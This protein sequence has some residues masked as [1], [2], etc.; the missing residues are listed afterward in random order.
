MAYLGILGVFVA[1]VGSTGLALV[2]LPA[3]TG[4]RPVPPAALRPWASLLLIG[5]VASM[6]ALEI[7]L[8]TDDFSIAYVANNHAAGTPLIFTIASAWA[9][10]EGSIVLWGLVIA[11]L[12]YAVYLGVVRGG[13]DVLGTGALSI[14]G[15]VGMFFFGLMVTVSN[16]FEVCTQAAQ[17]GCVSSSPLPWAAASIPAA[18]RGTNPLLQNHILMAVHPPLLYVGYVG[19]T[20]PFGFAM[21]SLLNVRSGAEWLIR[22]RRWTLMA[23]AFLTGGIVL[24]GWWSYEVLGWGGY[25]AWDPVE[26]ASFIPWLLAT[27]FLHSSV[28]QARRGVLQSWNYVLVIG[29]FSA[30]ILGTFLTRSGTIASVHSFTQSPVGP[31]ILGFLVVV[32]VG[33]IAVFATRAHLVASAPRLDSLVS[34]EGVFLL[35]NLL[36]SV[37]AFV[38]LAGTLFPL[39]VEAF[40]GAT[41]SVGPPFFDRWAIPLAF[42]LLLAMG[43]GPVTPYRLANPAIVWARIKTPLRVALGVGAATV[44]FASRIGYVVLVPMLAAFVIAVITRHLW[45]L[46]SARADKE[47]VSRAGAALGL[48]RRE[49]GYWGG[50]ISHIGVA[51]LAA[52]I[53]LSANLVTAAELRLPLD[54]PVEFAGFELTYTS[55]FLRN[56]PTRR[57]IGAEVEVRRDGALVDVLEPRIN[58]YTGSLQGIQTPAVRTTAA[59]DLYL[60]P[61]SLDTNEVGVDAWRYPMQWLVWFGGIL[62]A[63]G[64]VVS[65]GAVRAR[66]R[67]QVG[68][69]A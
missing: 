50:Q 14:V 16:P 5:S 63:L 27:A 8:L 29:T 51:V 36:L 37:F 44:L 49:P 57:V 58:E 33:S 60:S 66:R 55:A 10:L 25:W 69:G 23:W 62:T 30:T 40:Q 41:V 38:V 19:M 26:N 56:E 67:E 18:G 68:A 53:A 39:L 21:A 2:G 42:A 7:A 13:D 43:V 9:A 48:I 15:M 24:G 35:N 34:R 32:L 17:A 4:R 28:V 20:I 61:T 6:V 1:L 47:G 3:L 31:A 45:T 59:G 12:A 64:A 46:A 11:V 22:T 52:G 54:Q 65:M